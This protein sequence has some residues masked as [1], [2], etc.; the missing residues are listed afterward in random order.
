MP[1]AKELEDAR[2]R[3]RGQE[4]F[5]NPKN[6]LRPSWFYQKNTEPQYESAK[7]RA[8]MVEQEQEAQY[9]QENSRAQYNHERDV[10]DPNALRLSFEEWKKL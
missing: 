2:S 4:Q 8:N 3:L 10:G 7:M 1:T 5:Y 9:R 6:T